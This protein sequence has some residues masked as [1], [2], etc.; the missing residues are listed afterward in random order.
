MRN[1]RGRRSAPKD[2]A[3]NV[4]NKHNSPTSATRSAGTAI[5][6]FNRTPLAKAPAGI[7]KCPTGIRGLDEITEGGLP[8]GRPTLVCGG[9]GCG[10]TLLAWSSSS[11]ASASSTSRASSWPS[12]RRPRSWP[13]TSPR[14]A[15]TSTAL[16][17][18]KKMAVDYVRVE[19]S[20]IEETG[21]YDLEGLFVRLGSDDRRGRRQARRARQR[22]RRSSPACPTR[23]SCAPSCAGSSAGSRR[24]ASPPSSPA[25]RATNTLT[26]HGLE[27]YVSDCVIF[28]DHRVANQVATRRLRIVKYRG[29]GPRH[30]RVPHADR[31]ATACRSCRSARWGWTTRCRRSASPTGIER[32]DAMLGGKGYYK[33]SSILVSGTAGTGKSSIAAAF[34]DSVCAPGR[35]VPLLLLRGVARR[36]S[37]ATWPPSAIDLGRWVTQGPA[38]VPLGPPDLYGLESTWSSSTSW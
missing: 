20:E 1:A 34:A 29:S 21:E 8:E 4:S 25:S 10:K 12:R 32:L 37:S 11:A 27:E 28:L 31:R 17:R 5:T 23:R 26:R 7:A 9:A 33:G 36:R 38:A 2:S 15:S 30:Q 35:A 19:R 6:R 13:R 22:W 14:W 18:R 16:I 24:R 3:V